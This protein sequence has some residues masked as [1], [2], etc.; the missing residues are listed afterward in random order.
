M[1]LILRLQ[2]CSANLNAYNTDFK[3]FQENEAILKY[4]ILLRECSLLNKSVANLLT[5]I[6]V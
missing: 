6:Y 4:L 2:N 1:I 3:K 5:N